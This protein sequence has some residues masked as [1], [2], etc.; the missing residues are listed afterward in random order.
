MCACECARELTTYFVQLFLCLQRQLPVK[1]CVCVCVC[2]KTFS[3]RFLF[4]HFCKWFI[5]NEISQSIH[6]RNAFISVIIL[7]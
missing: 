6:S 3:S 2:G 5:R 1:I 7:R 4:L